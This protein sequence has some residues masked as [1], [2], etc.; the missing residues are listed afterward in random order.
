MIPKGFRP[1]F[2]VWL[3]QVV[4]MFGSGLTF[5]AL[6]VWVFQRTGKA[7]EYG[8]MLAISALPALALSPIL[9]ALVDRYDRRKVMILADVGAALTSLALLLLMWSGRL[10]MWHVLIIVAVGVTCNTLQAPA[11]H[12][13]IPLLVPQE[14]LGR[15]GGFMQF[16]MSGAQFV[17]P[18][19]G[20]LL[21]APLGMAGIIG[22][23]FA[24]FLFSMLM[25]FL[26][27]IPKPEA[28]PA[29]AGQKPSM[30]R[31]IGYG[32]KYIVDRPGFVSLVSF[33]AI[34][35]LFFGVAFAL[36]T[37]LVLTTHG[38]AALGTV[39]SLTIGGAVA[40]GLIM[41]AW[42]GPKSRMVGVLGFSFLVGLG[43]VIAGLKPSLLLLIAGMILV[44]LMVPMLSICNQV[45]WQ[46]KVEPSVQGRVHALRQMVG[47]GSA[48]LA[49]FLAGP[50]ADRVFEPMFQ[51]GGSMAA[52]AG[53]I[54][55][56]GPGRGI[57]FLFVLMGIGL[58]ATALLGYFYPR[59]RNL[60]HEIPDALPPAPPAA[61]PAPAT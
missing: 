26:I 33:V 18:L 43:L 60:E 7:S 13:S 37:P 1:F 20:G 21:L 22:I 32:W 41:T 11:F 48:P 46:T 12:S 14:H 56:T 58:S 8:L 44:Y 9:G 3:G 6:G 42:G 35:N 25:L 40:G 2:L 39:I 4:S 34:L 45:I 27:R 29:E 15:V 61:E 28:S 31:E 17:A 55:G 52:S 5:F 30:M 36:L 53:Q 16:G 59:L 51:P 19:A 47:Q 49:Y 50:L 38:P 24:T 23:D 54:L 57:G 10:E